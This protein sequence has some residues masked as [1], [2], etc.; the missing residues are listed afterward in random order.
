[1]F[2]GNYA[3]SPAQL[4]AKATRERAEQNRDRA[5]I[6]GTVHVN[7]EAPV[8]MDAIADTPEAAATKK[9]EK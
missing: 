1:M 2:E 3:A 4:P 9:S 8:E 7:G 5:H 6:V